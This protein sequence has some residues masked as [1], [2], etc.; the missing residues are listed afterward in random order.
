MFFLQLSSL[1]PYLFQER[2]FR[3]ESLGRNVKPSI[4]LTVTCK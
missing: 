3:R 4:S 1:Q 2:N